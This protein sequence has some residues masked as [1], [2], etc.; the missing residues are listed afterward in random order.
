MVIL[1]FKTSQD[2]FKQIE[3]K[4]TVP[5]EANPHFLGR[6]KFLESLREKLSDISRRRYNHRVA[7]HGMGGIGRTQWAIGY[8]RHRDLDERTFRI[9]AV[10]RSSL[11]L[12][13]VSIAKAA[14]LPYPS[15]TKP[16]DV[17]DIVF[18]QKTTKLFGDED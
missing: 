8:V 13:Y 4:F 9:T 18:L 17:A 2:S 16:S 7:L 5:Y 6:N 3:N 11:V 15:E 14:E 1:N 10:D 12:R